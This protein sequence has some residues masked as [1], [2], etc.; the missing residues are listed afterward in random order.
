MKSCIGRAA[1]GGFLA[2][3]CLTVL[4]LSA[5][6]QNGL[7]IQIDVDHSSFAYGPDQSLVE[8]YLAIDAASLDYQDEDGAFTAHVPLDM[9]IV[10]NATADL[11]EAAEQTVWSDSLLL[12]FTISDTAAITSGQH[13]VHQIRTLV[14]PGEYE[15]RLTVPPNLNTDRQELELRRDVLVPSFTDAGESTLSD[16][17]LAS[18]IDRG[19]ERENPFYKNG[20]IIRPNANQLYGEGLPT[21]YY[22]A[23]A[24]ETDE[25]AGTDGD[26]TLFAYVAEANRPQPMQGFQKRLEREARDPDVIVGDFDLS[27]LPS[28]SYFLRVALLNDE[29]ESVVEQSRKFFVYNPGVE[30]SE[31]E[32]VSVEF[33]RSPYAVM[34]EQEVEQ[35]VSHALLIANESERRRIRRVDDLDQRRR[36]LMEFWQKRD[37]QP[38]TV[39]N[40]FKE[41]FYRRIQYATDRY[42]TNRQEGW[43]TDRG[44]I[45]IRYGMP[46]AVEPHMYD[47]G[48]KPHE[49]WSYNSIPGEG[50]SMFIF[51]DLNGFGEFEL[52]HSSVTGERTHPNWRQELSQR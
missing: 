48:M 52:L 47:P 12:R 51:A 7:P 5:F 39:V 20:L 50:Q 9:A 23:E 28:G 1:T 46:A 38:S 30:R 10:Q 27:D 13:F 11:Q 45:I 25:I 8:L 14:E 2:A 40:E 36:F 4:N 22:Y 24:Y 44:R 6:A 26:Y 49:I 37:S 17:T 19:T 15:L 16:I 3:I 31:A 41:D 35:A 43:E 34:S 42:S 21:L 33:E 32:P 29:N 18:M